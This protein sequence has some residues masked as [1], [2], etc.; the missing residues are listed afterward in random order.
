MKNAI[1]LFGIFALVV[2][3]GFSMI[4]CKMDNEYE[5]INGDWDFGGV[6]VTITNDKGVFKEI[7][8]GNWL[9]ALEKGNISIGDMKIRKILKLETPLRWQWQERQISSDG[10]GTLADWVYTSVDLSKDGNTLTR[11]DG[12]TITRR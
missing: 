6:I 8:G 4:G 5:L 2:I 10:S 1:K 12:S 11:R 9:V 3:I 7:T